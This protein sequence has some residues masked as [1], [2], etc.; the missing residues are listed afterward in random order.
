MSSMKETKELLKFGIELGEA[1]DKS[2]AD[3]K[4]DLNDAGHFFYA[5]GY[6]KDAFQGIKL[7]GGELAKPTAEE[8][9]ELKQ[10][11][12]LELNIRN[13]KVEEAIERAFATVLSIYQLYVFFRALRAPAVVEAAP[14]AELAPESE[15]APVAEIAPETEAP[16]A[17]EP[18]SE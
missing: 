17:S 10:Y 1:F 6:A 8:F 9:L 18:V 15:A 5:L 14:V 13:D 11:V 7:V 3:G 2:F 16:A 4:L 12:E